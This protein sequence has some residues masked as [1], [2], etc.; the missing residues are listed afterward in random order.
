MAVWLPASNRFYL[1]PQPITRVQ[2]TEEYVSRTNIF[3]HGAT[4]RLLTV[5]HPYYPIIKNQ[6][7][8][9]PKVS[10]NQYR[11]FRI[12][13]PDPNNFAFGDKDIFDPEKER[14]VWGLRGIEIE[15]G[16]PL[17]INLTG[18]VL[19]NRYFDAENPFNADNGHGKNSEQRA[20]IAFDAKQVQM[21]MVG[22][23]PQTGQYWDIA[24]ACR[25]EE[26][27]VGECPPIEMKNSLIQDGDMFDI[28]FGALNFAQ[29]QDNKSDVPLD[30]VNTKSVYPDF[31]KM[32]EDRFGDSLFFFSRREQMYC[33]HMYL[34]DGINGGYSRQLAE[35]A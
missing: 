17:G 24:P 12:K 26:P 3:Y 21:I 23:K 33:R 27:L 28:G 32:L 6:A 9:V 16:Q 4:E 2:S 15:R 14:L 10:P 29:L 18:H 30:I 25:D 20:N 22:C 7:E 35:E 13:L 1:P 31:V 11:S 34:R 8:I 5:G 19:F